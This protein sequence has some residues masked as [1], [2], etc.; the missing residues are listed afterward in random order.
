[1]PFDYLLIIKYHFIL[2]CLLFLPIL[3]YFFISE[4]EYDRKNMILRTSQLRLL[5]ECPPFLIFL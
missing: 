2:L 5:T 3:F 4:R 1:M